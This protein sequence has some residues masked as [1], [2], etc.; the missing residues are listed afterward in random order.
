ME[1]CQ[2]CKNK[3]ALIYCSSCSLYFCLECDRITHNLI[4][5]KN[6]K[7]KNNTSTYLSLDDIK[8][9]FNINNSNNT[10]YKS[11]KNNN[12][13]FKAYITQNDFHKVKSNEEDPNVRLI[14]KLAYKLNN[15]LDYNMNKLKNEKNNIQYKNDFNK[16][17]KLIRITNYKN[18]FDINNLLNIIEQQD[19]I[20]ND[21]FIKVNFLKQVIKENIFIETDIN[22]LDNKNIVKDE[23]YFDKK[24]DIISKMYEK[25]KE[26]LIRKQEDKILKIKLEYDMVKDKY[27]NLI[28][29][30]NKNENVNVN[31]NE[32]EEIY[33][34]IKK[35][36][37]DQIDINTNT[38][39]LSIIKDEL[40]NTEFC[41]N[42]HLDELIFKLGNM[43][44]N[45]KENENI[46][47]KNKRLNKYN[48]KS[49][50]RK[51]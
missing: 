23:N 8:K 20:I 25:E 33:N 5:N 11:P 17:Y 13:K 43:K 42:E 40:N 32:T 36:K 15:D 27:L 49:Y 26:E 45:S 34:I 4:K 21:L 3:I 10:N 37:S 24:L 22:K 35:L 30:K 18:N 16:L 51:I 47:Y 6:H 1:K 39:K 38:N 28:K 41:I 29:Q 14:N 12:T 9:N 7:R 48:N 31:V 19:L 46:I 2:K 50:N 44:N